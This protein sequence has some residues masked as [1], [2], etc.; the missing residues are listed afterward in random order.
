MLVLIYKLPSITLF[1]IT[2]VVCKYNYRYLTWSELGNNPME[3]AILVLPDPDEVAF[4]I[5]RKHAVQY[6]LQ[7]LEKNWAIILK[8][9]AQGNFL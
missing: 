3:S 5:V 4:G 8:I 9:I 1:K 6:V 7:L 2:D